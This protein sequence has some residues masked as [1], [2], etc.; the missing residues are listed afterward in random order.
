VAS[1]VAWVVR[2]PR[3]VHL[4]FVSVHPEAPAGE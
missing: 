3:S 1:S 2:V 4:D